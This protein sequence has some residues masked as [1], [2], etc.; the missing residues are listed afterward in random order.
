MS[1][2]K[3]E[4]WLLRILIFAAVS[5]LPLAWLNSS[6]VRVA[7]YELLLPQVSEA[8]RREIYAALHENEKRPD[9][10][11]RWRLRLAENGHER[12][13]IWRDVERAVDDYGPYAAR[14]LEPEVLAALKRRSGLRLTLP[15]TVVVR[16][17]LR[18]PELIPEL[19]RLAATPELGSVVGP[20]LALNGRVSE[21]R[22]LMV[23][24]LERAHGAIEDTSWNGVPPVAELI[25]ALRRLGPQ[26]RPALPALRRW[27]RTVRARVRAEALAALWALDRDAEALAELRQLLADR[28][29]GRSRRLRVSTLKLAL[30]LAEV[31][32]GDAECR[33]I[34]EG[35]L[36]A[37]DP[38]PKSA[39]DRAADRRWLCLE[40]LARMGPEAAPSR[41]L[42]A[43]LARHE[44]P[45]IARAAR[46]ALAAIDDGSDS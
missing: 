36:T 27:R 43:P 20:A 44:H 42:I 21:G 33:A 11:W 41:P 4:R 8:T 5:T 19:L 2:A 3:P 45:A 17:E 31:G 23:A 34:F 15:L 38:N 37:G 6:A 46:R 22:A 28:R 13:I 35:P 18:D 39:T 12:N 1:A 24:A 26:A 14:G 30:L 16:A 10:V 7:V 29:S 25:A 9:V 32:Q 40:A